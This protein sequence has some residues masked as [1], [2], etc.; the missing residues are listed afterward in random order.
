[1]KKLGSAV[2]PLIRRLKAWSQ[3]RIY[4]SQA[5]AHAFRDAN[6]R[7][8]HPTAFKRAGAAP[9]A[10]DETMQLTIMARLAATAALTYFEQ[11]FEGIRPLL[12]EYPDEPADPR[13][14]TAQARQAELQSLAKKVDQALGIDLA[15]PIFHMF[16]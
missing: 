1:M 7:V 8:V 15:S 14:M 2:K 5:M 9:L 3:L 6:G 16:A 4:R 10:S 12:E 13:G 11:E